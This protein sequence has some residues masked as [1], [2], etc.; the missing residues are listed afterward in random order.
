MAVSM[1]QRP[2]FK[3]KGLFNGSLSLAFR[4]VP[5]SCMLAAKLRGRGATGAHEKWFNYVF[6]FQ[7]N[8]MPEIYKAQIARESIKTTLDLPG[9]LKEKLPQAS[10]PI[11]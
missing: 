3:A 11:G 2:A 6:L 10:M 9:P 1:Q 4:Y 7:F 5:L 8:Q